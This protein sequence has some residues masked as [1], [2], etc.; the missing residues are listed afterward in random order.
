MGT[1]KQIDRNGV[2]LVSALGQQ[3]NVGINCVDN[4]KMVR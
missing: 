3:Q 4:M 1:G 2:A